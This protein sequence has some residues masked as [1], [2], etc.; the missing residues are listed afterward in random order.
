GG[1]WSLRGWPKTTI[2]LR[3]VRLFADVPVSG[4]VTWNV[5]SGEVTASLRADGQ[6]WAGCWRAQD[7]F[8]PGSTAE[9]GTVCRTPVPTLAP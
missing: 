4:T 5:D 3:D 2:T 6:D 7:G 8:G 1:R 9:L